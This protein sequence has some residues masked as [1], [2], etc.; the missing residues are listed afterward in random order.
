MKNIK[1][2][3][4]WCADVKNQGVF[5]ILE[6]VSNSKIIIT[7]PSKCDIL[8]IGSYDHEFYS[9]KRKIFN[10]VLSKKII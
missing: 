2:G 10:K 9:F 3:F 4:L 5:K 8:F 1:I 6:K 7:E